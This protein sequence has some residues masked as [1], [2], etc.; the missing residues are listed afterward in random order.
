MSETY[1]WPVKRHNT[2]FR[3]SS[4]TTFTSAPAERALV[5][6]ISSPDNAALSRIWSWG[7]W[8]KWSCGREAMWR[9]GRERK[10]RKRG[11]R[12]AKGNE[13]SE[14]SEEWK[15]KYSKTRCQLLYAS[16]ETRHQ[17][18]NIMSPLPSRP[19]QFGNSFVSTSVAGTQFIFVF[20]Y[21]FSF[22]SQR[23]REYGENGALLQSF[24]AISF[25]ILP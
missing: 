24:A 17:F 21:L 3:P 16:W 20:I 19:D 6:A 22:F 13:A 23:S 1:S 10:G 5:K 4:L 11:R 18:T 15:V 8:G 25:A 7:G 9:L 14:G 12:R 2:A